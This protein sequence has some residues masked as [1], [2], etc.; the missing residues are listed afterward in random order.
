[1]DGEL[2][3]KI[4]YAALDKALEFFGLNN[5]WEIKIINQRIDEEGVWAQITPNV[6]YLF[7][8]IV[9]D[10]GKFNTPQEVWATIGHEIAHILFAELNLFRKLYKAPSGSEKV[11]DFAEERIVTRLS[12]LFVRMNPCPH[13]FP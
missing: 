5:E 11:W 10:V 7:S 1:M 3:L 8:S 9:L 6:E 4:A 2:C 12:R 13:D